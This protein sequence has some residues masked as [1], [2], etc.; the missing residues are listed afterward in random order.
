MLILKV[1]CQNKNPIDPEV[2]KDS[3][4]KTCFDAPKNITFR[5]IG[6]F[7]YKAQCPEEYPVKH[8]D[9]YEEYN[10]KHITKDPQ[11]GRKNHGHKDP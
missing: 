10:S 8:G 7:K 11:R 1:R 3:I 9:E 4:H 2:I 6:I 5:F